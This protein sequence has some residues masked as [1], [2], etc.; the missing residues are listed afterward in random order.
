MRAV[1]V[2]AAVRQPLPIALLRLTWHRLVL[3]LNYNVLYRRQSVFFVSENRPGH[4]LRPSPSSEAI[5]LI[6]P[7]AEGL[8]RRTAYATIKNQR[9]NVGRGG[10]RQTFHGGA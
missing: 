8:R 3:L 6:A 7:S 4:E 10:R 2:A 5:V 1:A 9:A